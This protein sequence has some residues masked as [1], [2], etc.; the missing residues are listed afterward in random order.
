MT[1]RDVDELTTDEYR[2]LWRYR[3]NHIRREN[4]AARR[5]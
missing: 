3:E 2:A 5:K 1:P 4:R